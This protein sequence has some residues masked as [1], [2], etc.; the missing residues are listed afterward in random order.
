MRREDGGGE[1]REVGQGGQ[2]GWRRMGQT[3]VG[4]RQV[5]T[6]CCMRGEGRQWEWEQAFLTHAM[7]FLPVTFP[8]SLPPVSAS[9]LPLPASTL[10]V[11][12]SL[13]HLLLMPSPKTL[14][15]YLSLLFCMSLQLCSLCPSA[16]STLCRHVSTNPLPSLCA[17]SFLPASPLPA[18]C[19]H[20]PAPPPPFSLLSSSFMLLLLAQH[21]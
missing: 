13:P 21:G 7:A 10:L 5:A 3:G 4:R 19:L 14:A 11:W 8:S 15:I 18:S 16:F 1:G 2:E 12:P 6:C 17:A 20:L 9:A